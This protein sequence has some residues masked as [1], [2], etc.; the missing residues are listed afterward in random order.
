MKRM[1][2]STVD[3]KRSNGIVNILKLIIIIFNAVN[4]AIIYRPNTISR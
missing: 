1:K 2:I 4:Q 3:I